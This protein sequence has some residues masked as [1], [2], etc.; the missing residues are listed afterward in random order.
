MTAALAGT[1]LVSAVPGCE[2]LSVRATPEAAPEPL[3][4][5]GRRP[6]ATANMVAWIEGVND[7][8]VYDLAARAEVLRVRA[9]AVPGTVEGLDVSADGRVAMA[10]ARRRTPRSGAGVAVAAPGEPPRVLPLPRSPYYETRL[11]G[12][13]VLVWRFD[14]LGRS[15]LRATRWRGA[16]TRLLATG[17]GG[18]DFDGRTV[19]WR[20]TRCRLDVVRTAPLRSLLRRPAIPRRCRPRR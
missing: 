15:E 19:A 16:R 2:A 17:V 9:R 4:A 18:F 20:T 14:F 11:A 8:V 13:R 5:D 3:A 6:A 1:T 12:R 7:V 10:F